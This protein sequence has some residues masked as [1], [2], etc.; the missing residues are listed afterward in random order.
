MAVF[1]FASAS[2]SPGVTT[3]VLACGCGWPRPVVVVEADPIA[4][5]PILAGYF[6]GMAEPPGGMVDLMVAHRQDQLAQRL[7]SVLM[8]IPDTAV[9]VLTGVQTRAQAVG[10]P[11]I[12]GSLLHALRELD[13]T[14]TDVVVDAGRLP[15]TGSFSPLVLGSD[16]LLLVV[17]SNV[18]GTA[19][20]RALVTDLVE[21][22][23]TGVG[24]VVVGPDRPYR[25]KEVASVLGL[26]L[27]GQVEWD[28]RAA[29][30]W[31]QGEQPTRQT[32]RSAFQRSL[33]ATGEAIRDFAG[34]ATRPAPQ[35]MRI[36]G[37]S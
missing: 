18:P 9:K 26:P 35:A 33:R 28:P 25:A 5:S 3:T 6:Q 32:Q 8:P 10:L 17:A 22:R 1:T 30:V 15:A 4:G 24:L 31:S 23:A 34:A 19:T 29:A 12:A 16:V 13:D 36:G 14:G 37:V 21:Q 27:L 11:G 20:A 7:A 2:G